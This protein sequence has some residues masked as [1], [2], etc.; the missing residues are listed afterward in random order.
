[1]ADVIVVGSMDEHV[2]HPRARPAPARAKAAT[3][4]IEVLPVSLL[5]EHRQIVNDVRRLSRDLK[6]GL[7]WHYLLDLAWIISRLGDPAGKTVL[8]AGAGW[9]VIQWYMCSRGATVISVDRASRAD[10]PIRFRVRYPLRGLR[11]SDVSPFGPSLMRELKSDSN[12]LRSVA[13]QLR[14]AVW[15]AQRFRPGIGDV[16]VYNQDLRDMPDIPSASID[17]VV[18]VSSLE[19]NPPDEL[20]D[21]V[22][23]LRRVLRPGGRLLATLGASADIDWFHQPSQGWC[24]SEATLRRIFDIDEAVPSNYSA[25][26]EMLD[27]L[28]ACAELRDNLAS[29]YF[30]SGQNGMP[31]GVWDPQYQPVGVMV[32]IPASG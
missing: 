31:W 8:D 14:N 16:V 5:D 17:A 27:A 19:H 24:Y 23:E 15:T 9:G 11:R 25:Y 32:S 7:G 6:I 1:M 29:F 3:E 2:D 20:V 10:I 21:V 18:A 30:T 26:G 28:V 4:A 13:R 12:A 22:R